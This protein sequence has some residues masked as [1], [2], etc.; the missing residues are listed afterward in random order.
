MYPSI[1]SFIQ[2]Y[3]NE[4]ASTQKLLDTLTDESLKLETASGYRTL[5]HL[6]WH[7]IPSGGLLQPT[8]LKF[9]APPEDAEP[10]ASASTIA[11]TYTKTVESLL[12]AVQTQWT[13]AKL[14]ETV[15]M[16]GQ[17]WTNGLTLQVFVRHE[18]HHRGQLT[19]L[20]R[21]AGLPIAGVYGPSKEEWIA[22]GMDAKA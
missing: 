19:V 12:E 10:P 15:N 1:Q 6:A 17:V 21:Q 2:D 18:I 13:D 8:G 9:D 3:R 7:L 16:F 11:Q 14:Q 5:G 22:M 4:S 20:M